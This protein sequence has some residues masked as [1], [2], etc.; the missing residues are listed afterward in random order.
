MIRVGFFGADHFS[1]GC[2]KAILPLYSSTPK[3]ISHLDVITRS[4]KL[5]GRGLQH[6]N[7]FPVAKFAKENDI[8]V[9]RAERNADFGFLPN[10]DLCIAVSYGKLIPASFLRSLPFGGLNVHPSLLPR[11]SG[12]APLQRALLNQDPMTGVTVQTLHPT[13]FD[14]GTILGRQY[15]K[16]K[17]SETYHSLV[18]ALSKSGGKVLYDILLN[19]KYDSTLPQYE[20][21]PPEVPFS[22]AKKVQ[23]EERQII[24]SRYD[25]FKIVRIF[26]T[27][28]HLYTFKK[29]QPRRSQ[30]RELGFR[31]VVLDDI[32]ESKEHLF[33]AD[34]IPGSFM[35]DPSDTQRLLVKT[36][37]G[38]ISVSNI[39][40]ESLG[41]VSPDRLSNPTKKMFGNVYDNVF[42]TSN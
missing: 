42:V 13:E 41:N 7:E 16:I 35:A 2:L 38:C 25:T 36:V 39:K 15:Y 40:V 29:Y 9:L 17:R 18:K 27:L 19:Q 37:D 12:P 5:G 28:G 6:L 26:N 32:Q 3:T 21:L 30:S 10:Y 20:T 14:K 24:W 22:Y 33:P 8:N 11:Y 1:V 31:R 4:P 34:S 23:P